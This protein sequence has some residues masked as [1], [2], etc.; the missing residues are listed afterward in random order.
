MVLLTAVFAAA[1]EAVD[2]T[3]PKPVF[4][5]GVVFTSLD[6]TR[7]MNIEEFRGRPVLLTFWA[8]W[9]GPCRVELPELSQ[10]YGEL[11][12]RGFVLITVNMDRHPMAGQRFLQALELSLPTYRLDPR[13]AKIL[14]VDALPTSVLLDQDGRFVQAYKGYTPSVVED[15]RRL[16]VEMTEPEQP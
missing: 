16:V 8:S 7:T 9:C 14:G 11:V 13:M 12:G 2:P 4:P 15:V 10:L 3:P 5:E 1:D 6:G